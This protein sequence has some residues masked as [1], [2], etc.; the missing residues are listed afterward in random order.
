MDREWVVGFVWGCYGTQNGTPKPFPGTRGRGEAII[1]SKMQK[2][3]DFESFEAR[4]GPELDAQWSDRAENFG[5]RSYDQGASFGAG[6]AVRRAQKGPKTGL[7]KIKK[8][9]KN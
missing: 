5:G 4:F 1:G 7:Q 8:S 6:G 3:W 2:N 9:P